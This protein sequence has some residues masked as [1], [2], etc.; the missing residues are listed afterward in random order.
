MTADQINRLLEARVRDVASKR[1][2]GEDGPFRLRKALGLEP[3]PPRTDLKAIITGTLERNGY[4]I[5][6]LRY[7]SRPSVL[8]TAHL[9]VP[10]GSGPFPIALRPHGHWEYKK[11]EPLV[12]ASAIGLALAG[13]AVLVVESPGWAWDDNLANERQG[14]GP[15][16]DWLLCAG[17]PAMGVYVWD[18]VRGLDYLESRRDMD[19]KRVGITG[20]SGGGTA[21]M[22]AFALDDRIM[23]AAPVCA[24]ASLEAAPHNGCLCNHLPGIVSLL[25]DRSDVF[26]L[27]PR[28][29]MLLV[30]AT[31]DDEFPPEGTRKTIE[32]IQ[33]HQ[34]GRSLRLEIVESAHDYNRRMREVVLAFFCEHLQGQPK[35]G[36]LPELRP[37]TDGIHN[38]YPANTDEP[39][40]KERWVTEPYERITR[41]FR[42]LLSEAM[43][44]PYPEPFDAA[45]RLVPWKHYGKWETLE[46]GPTLLLKD[47]E[48]PLEGLDQRSCIFLGLSVPELFAQLYHLALPAPAEAWDGVDAANRMNAVTSMIAS[49]RTLVGG[50]HGE[51]LRQITA[52]GPVSSMIARHL[53]LLRPGV[54]VEV[55]H[56]FGGW[57]QLLDLDNPLVVQPGARYLAWPFM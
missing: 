49:M 16:D 23:C 52:Q 47:E 54:T 4:R 55:S 38:P 37:L 35:R 26:A 28:A 34:H 13:F 24:A 36:Y 31:E 48:L 6:K 50:D 57:G 42:E 30:G 22:Y 15:H 39:R 3:L 44:A 5:E 33:H 1:F 21:T 51:P 32:K 40:D 17:A 2:V 8:V 46:N 10:N 53:K 20:A 27:R 9:Y 29:P 11:S 12:Q 7:E 45:T 56:T 41:T 19:T 43:A 25:G 14:M 18:L